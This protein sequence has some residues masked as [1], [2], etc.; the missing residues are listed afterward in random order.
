MWRWQSASP[1]KLFVE[2]ATGCYQ[3]SILWLAIG[4][5]VYNGQ[6][7]TGKGRAK[8]AGVSNEVCCIHL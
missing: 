4:I 7:Q 6:E 2:N 8:T 3:A 1:K 5:A